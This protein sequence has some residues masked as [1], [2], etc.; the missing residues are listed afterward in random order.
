MV[1]LAACGGGDDAAPAPT[2]T[3]ISS[4]SPSP[5]PTPTA[6]PS[7]SPTPTATPTGSPSPSPTPT[8]T[9]S[10][11][12]SPTPTPTSTPTATPSPSPTPTPTS[13]PTPTPT[14][15]AR[16]Y[17]AIAFIQTRA[18]LL[19][20]LNAQGARGFTFFG[21]LGLDNGTPGNINDDQF[22]NF[23]VKD[24]ATTYV[25]EI[26]DT[27]ASVSALLAQMN[28]QGARGF[29]FYGPLEVGTLYVK[30]SAGATYTYE[31]LSATDTNAN[32]LTQANSQG[33]RGFFYI[34]SYAVDT[35]TFVN[36][37][38]KVT[39]SAAKYAY[40]L[41]PF[42]DDPAAFVT[43]ANAQG[44]E[45]YRFVGGA[46]FLGEPVGSDARTRNVYVRDTAQSA[47]F[48]W[49]TAAPAGTATALVTQANA[50][51]AAGFLYYSVV[52]FS[53]NGTISSR[54][55]YFRPTSCVGVLC[56]AAG[57]F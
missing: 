8:P 38:A 31:L 34:G 16:N 17:E 36:I 40:R 5:S 28:A 56:R 3:P 51:A 4:G 12:P 48:E 2:P 55:L 35:T 45:G 52:G 14:A 25:N 9:G 41:Q 54:E 15:A 11:S 32:F 30:E 53:A 26:L 23:Y 50:E 22:V 33:D 46:A 57:P 7:P 39:G 19:T 24:S 47:R 13:T 10:P 49:K 42:L 18:E 37:Y 6:S 21:P 43:Q 29:D 27:P 20:Q 44:Q 1:V